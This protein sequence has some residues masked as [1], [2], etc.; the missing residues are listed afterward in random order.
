MLDRNQTE[1]QM[2]SSITAFFPA[3]ND[4]HTIE[5]MVKSAAAELRKVTNDFEVLVVNDGSR[6]DTANVLRRVQD[7]VPELRVIHHA[8]NR[9]YGAALITGFTNARKDFIFYTD[10]DGQYDVTEIH[11]LLKAVRPDVDV[12][13]GFK[14]QRADAWYRVWIGEAYRRSMRVFFNLSVRDVDCDFRLF[15]RSIFERIS[16]QSRSGV[17]C[18]ELMR[19]AQLAGCRIVEVPVSHWPRQYGSSQFFCFRHL[20]GVLGGLFKVWWALV[21]SH[22]LQLLTPGVRTPS[23]ALLRT[24]RR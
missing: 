7:E 14:I 24:L 22:H 9:G 11:S 13:T 3:Y 1:D 12:V 8:E 17:I 18:V 23:Q 5:S 15:R 21:L 6:D 4:Q 19:K 16:L 10:G 20:A 2:N